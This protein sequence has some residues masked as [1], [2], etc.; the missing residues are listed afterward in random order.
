M[1]RYKCTV[2]YDGSAYCGWQT[3]NT[4]ASVQEQIEAAV[5]H[6]MNRPVRVLAAGRTDAGVNAWGQVFQ[7]DTEMDVSE[8]TMM[9]AINGHL[10]GDIHIR[11]VEKK[12]RLFHAR[13]CVRSKS[14]DYRINLGEYDVFTRTQAYQCPYPVDIERMKQGAQYLIGKHD[15]T[16]FNSNS[17]KETP[18]QVR[19][20]E[21][22]DFI[23]KNNLLTISYRG[24][25]FLRYMVRMMTAQLLDVGRGKLEP[26]DI[27]RILEAKSK[28]IARRNAHPE[29][30]TLMEIDYYETLALT[31]TTAV[32]EYLPEDTLNEGMVLSEVEEA[33]RNNTYPQEYVIADRHTNEPYGSYYLEETGGE[34]RLE[35]ELKEADLEN[36]AEQIRDTQKRRGLPETLKIAKKA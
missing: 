33:V 19:T 27:K 13:Y 18:D 29:G 3:Q 30:L 6:I 5:S 21:S 1:I 25:G 12:D 7:F 4:G 22:I 11:K 16:S 34:L 17:L 2:A 36:L 28:T 23:L 31:E 15:F 8:R 35:K 10:P 32:R 20:I 24:R 9:G 14:Y 26:E